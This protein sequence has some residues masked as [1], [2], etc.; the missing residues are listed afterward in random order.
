MISIVFFGVQLLLILLFFFKPVVSESKQIKSQY[1]KY[2]FTF[3]VAFFLKAMK[4]TT[5]TNIHKNVMLV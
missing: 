2:S 5:L 3:A 4:V 1:E